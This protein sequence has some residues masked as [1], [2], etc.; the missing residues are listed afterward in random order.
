MRGH[1]NIEID[2][3]IYGVLVSQSKYHRVFRKATNKF[4]KDSAYLSD[5]LLEAFS[6]KPELKNKFL[7][8]KSITL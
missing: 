4:K 6:N 7:N 2:N 1:F 8:N 3:Q 5:E